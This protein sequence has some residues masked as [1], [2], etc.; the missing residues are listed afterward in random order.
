MNLRKVT[1]QFEGRHEAA[2]RVRQG[3]CFAQ[4]ARLRLRSPVGTL[5][6]F[7]ILLIFAPCREASPIRPVSPNTKT[8][9]GFL[10]VSLS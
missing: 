4:R 7:L 8:R 9:T 6:Y 5:A 3:N 10:S 2:E 1:D